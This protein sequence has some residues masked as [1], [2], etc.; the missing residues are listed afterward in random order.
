MGVKIVSNIRNKIILASILIATIILSIL[1]FACQATNNERDDKIEMTISAGHASSFAIKAD[2]S[3]WAW[4]SN[5]FGKLGDGTTVERH[6]PVEIM[7][8]V[9]S[10]SAGVHHTMAICT[11]GNLWAWGRNSNGQ[12][13][14]G[15]TINRYSPVRIM[16]DI[17]AVSAGAS[18]TMAIKTDNSLWAWGNYLVIGG[19]VTT[20]QLYPIK[21]MADVVAVSAGISHTAIIKTDNSLWTWGNNRNGQLGD[22]TTADRHSPV[23]VIDNVAVAYV[24]DFH[25]V[26]IRTDGSLWTWGD[27][28]FGQLGDGTNI[29][30][31]TPVQVMEDVIAISVGLYYT[32][33]IKSDGS[34]WSW[35]ENEDGQLGDGTTTERRT[36][37]QVQALENIV[38]I[39]ACSDTSLA[40]RNDGTVW[41]WGRNNGR[42]G[43]G[44]TTTR[45]I[46]VQTQS[47]ENIIEIAISESHSLALRDDGTVW[48]WGNNHFGQLGDNTQTDSLTPVQVRGL[49][50][51]IAIAAGASY[52]LA[53]RDDGTVWAWGRNGSGELGDGT[54]VSARFAPVRV[55]NLTNITCIIAGVTSGN[56]GSFAI[57]DDGTVWAWGLVRVPPFSGTHRTPVQIECLNDVNTIAFGISHSF[58]IRNDGTVLAWGRNVDGQLGDGSGVSHNAPTQIQNLTNVVDIAVSNNLNGHS[59]ALKADGTV[60]AWGFNSLGRLGTGINTSH[61]RTPAQVVG[62]DG[63][64]FLNL[65]A[66][67]SSNNQLTNASTSSMMTIYSYRADGLRHSKTVNGVTTTH[68]WLMGN[69]VLERGRGGAIINQFDRSITGRIIRSEQHGYYLHNA[70][71]D[72]VQRVNSQGKVLRNYR[73]TA[74]GIELNPDASNANPFRFA[75]EYWDAETGTYYLRARN[76][77]PRTGRF[78]Q[79]DP[80]WGIGNMIF[81]DSPTMRNGRMMP[82]RNSIMQA[83]NLFVYCINNPVRWNDPSGRIIIPAMIISTMRVANTAMNM[84]SSVSGGGSSGFSVGGGGLIASAGGGGMVGVPPF[85][86]AAINHN[87]QIFQ[88]TGCPIA[89]QRIQT[90]HLVNSVFRSRADWVTAQ[91][92]HLLRPAMP[93][94][95][96]A[97]HSSEWILDTLPKTGIIIHHTGNRR[98]M[99]EVE[100]HH[101][102]TRG[103]A[104]T[105]YHFGI[106]RAGTIYE[107]RPLQYL[108]VHT[109]GYNSGRI[110]I[111]LL[112]NFQ[113][114]VF[115]GGEHP[116]D[117][118]LASL[119]SL[120]TVLQD[121]LGIS[122][123]NITSHR[124]HNPNDACPGDNL[125]NTLRVWGW[126]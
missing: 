117:A 1:V 62:T 87:T 53:L 49:S 123:D 75:G 112:G 13:G 5:S 60:W 42:L 41:G 54:T 80:H 124:T 31:H 93:L 107:G 113:P 43:D 73:Y 29:E 95:T 18:H 21:I 22:G 74:F 65:I 38:K 15:T 58:A 24:G 52:S 33:A 102:I 61:H 23:Q 70:R 50:N 63:Q 4:G 39:V 32:M 64:G 14:D 118:Q 99:A 44:T 51:V 89:R 108:G 111:A 110:G 104:S 28:A 55:Q 34:L 67:E 121:G 47:L 126:N 115:G 8:N 96:F 35:G 36:P 119:V 82:N 76:F 101:V 86:Q 106:S 12:L 116:S 84:A 114:G 48:A 94:N 57:R 56:S 37:V 109:A 79:P 10:V 59:V 46:P 40:L 100:R 17:V 25:T 91:W 83:S 3:L 2:G 30:R 69:I 122:S 72:V 68:V 90:A 66:N 45:H 98:T 19:D 85:I 71:G 103:W 9:A 125:Y 6:T 16:G 81:G 88:A 92:Q 97:V 77:N 120:V 20:T 11:D 27:N 78:T 7:D 105:G 26:A